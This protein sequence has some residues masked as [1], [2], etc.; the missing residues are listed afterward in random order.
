[1]TGDVASGFATPGRVADMDG[2]AE[3]QVF[4]D[5][6]CVSGVMVHIVAVRHLARAP[7]A[8]TIDSHD[9]I[10]LL[11][12]EKHLGIPVVRAERPAMVDDDGLAVTPVFAKDLNAVF[13]RNRAHGLGSLAVLVDIESKSGI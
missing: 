11:N 6:R 13:G 2:I 9:T 12:E 8:A 3:V 10:P 4:G 5:G 1:M 7:V